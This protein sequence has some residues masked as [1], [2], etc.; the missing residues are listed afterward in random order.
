MTYSMFIDCSVSLACT[1]PVYQCCTKYS[2]YMS[3]ALRIPQK[4]SVRSSCIGIYNTITLRIDCFDV[5]ISKT[6]TGVVPEL[7]KLYLSVIN[8]KF[9]MYIFSKNILKK[10]YNM[11]FKQ[12]E[13]VN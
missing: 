3:S 7:K 4:K 13:V 11:K 5:D 8:S 6:Y 2:L 1:N 10:Y 12:L 9:L